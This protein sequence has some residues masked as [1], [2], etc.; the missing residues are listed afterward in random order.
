MPASA[1]IAQTEPLRPD[2]LQVAI[3]GAGATGVEL[4]AELHKTTRELVAFGLDRI[5]P[6]KDISLT[7]SRPPTAS[8]RRCRR[9]S[10][11]PRRSC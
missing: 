6:D 10:R 8:C 9:G 2:Q 7:S 5:D 4:A 1:R 11:K 3:I